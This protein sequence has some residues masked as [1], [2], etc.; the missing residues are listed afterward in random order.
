M[1]L[2]ERALRGAAGGRTEM[3]WRPQG[4]VCELWLGTPDKP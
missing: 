1:N 2:L 3:E 4:L